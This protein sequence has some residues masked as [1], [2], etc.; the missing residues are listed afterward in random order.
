MPL[1]HCIA[2]FFFFC[3]ATAPDALRSFGCQ[4]VVGGGGSKWDSCVAQGRAAVFSGSWPAATATNNNKITGSLYGWVG[5]GELQYCLDLAAT[6]RRHQQFHGGRSGG[7]GEEVLDSYFS[8]PLGKTRTR[9]S[10]NYFPPDW[11][12]WEAIFEPIP[13]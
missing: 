3:H 13:G 1:W 9:F 12:Q 6:G 8:F 7:G 2:F 11:F 5:R 10:C 4:F